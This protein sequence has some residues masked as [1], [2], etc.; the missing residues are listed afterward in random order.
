MF[1]VKFIIDN[2]EKVKESAANKNITVDVDKIV[3]LYDVWKEKLMKLEI[4]R[5][6]QNEV[7]K[8]IP[9]AKENKEIL[10][11]KKAAINYQE[12]TVAELKEMAKKKGLTGISQL[13]K[14]ELIAKLKATK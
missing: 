7:S 13:T 1:D 9:N 3:K 11:E 2:P 12:K 4:L 14:P 6:R 10:E 5:A 8:E